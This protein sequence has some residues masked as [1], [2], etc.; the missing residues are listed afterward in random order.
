MNIAILGAGNSGCALAADYAAR[1]HDVTLIKTSHSLHDDNFSHLCTT[2]GRMRI[3]EFGTDTDCVIAHLS[4]DAAD[5]RGKDAVL[6][7]TQTG[8]HHDVLRRVVPFLTAGQI[9]LMIPGYLSTAY[10]LGLHPADGVIFAEAESNFI[11]GRICAPGEFQVGFRNVRNP[12]GVYPHSALPAAQAV[13]DRL[14]T[15]FVYL[16]SV[17]EAALHNPNMIVHTVGAIMTIPRIEGTNGDYCMYHEAFTPSVWNLLEALDGEKMRVLER[18]GCEG[19]PYVE[20]CKFRN[21][22]DEQSDAKAV[23]FAYAAMPERAKGPLSVRSRYIMEDVPQG[24]GL[25][26]SL[27]ASRGVPTPVCS[28]LIEIASAALGCDLRAQGRTIERLGRDNIRAI[29]DDAE[30]GAD[31]CPDGMR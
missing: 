17:A 24:L 13:L 4:R 29:L 26:E 10:A 3:H 30:R 5:V 20:A 6:L 18:L 7:C 8:Y 1:G 22:L 14:G 2:G 23:F 21:S 27:G 31:V 15:P 12:I 25:L 9:L 16:K 11:D 28:S 19:V